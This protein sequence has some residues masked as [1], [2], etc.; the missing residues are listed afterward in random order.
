[1][2]FV[3]GDRVR[4]KKYADLPAQMKTKGISRIAGCE[5]EIV[6]KLISDA[7]GCTIYKIHLDGYASPSRVEFI[8]TA[9]DLVPDEEPPRYTYE[10]EFLENLVVARLYEIVG[11]EKVEVGKGHGHIFHDGV[12]GI[13][14]AASYALKKIYQNLE[15]N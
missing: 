1:M 13:A 8:K 5:G 7:K 3:I 15:D 4:I 9:I 12:I 2:E 11:D 14:Q 6:D 10:F